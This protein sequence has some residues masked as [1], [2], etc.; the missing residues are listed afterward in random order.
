MTGDH[1]ESFE[2]GY[3]NHGEELYESS[4]HVP[5]LIR[6]PGQQ[7]GKRQPGLVAITQ[8]RAD[9]SPYRRASCAKLDGGSTAITWIC[10]GAIGRGGQLQTSER[11]CQLPIADAISAMVG[12]EYM[13]IAACIFGAILRLRLS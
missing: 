8:Y 9:H 1:G 11:R 5:L 10:P 2:R 12:A 3:L 4:T 7:D 6:Y 13:L